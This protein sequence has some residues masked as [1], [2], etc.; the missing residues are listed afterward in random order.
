MLAAGASDSEDFVSKISTWATTFS[1]AILLTA[2]LQGQETTPAPTPIFERDVLPIL[3][4]SCLKCHGGDEPEAGLDL[5]TPGAI[6]KG[7]DNGPVVVRNAADKSI[8]FEKISS[9]EMPPGEVKLTE[10]AVQ[11]L[12]AWID[13]GARALQKVE[14]APLVSENDRQHWAFRPPVRPSVPKVRQETR[15]R[16]PVDSFLLEKLEAKNL[17]FADDADRATLLRRAYLDLWGLP[18]T[19]EAL[20]GFAADQGPDSYELLLDRLLASPRFGERWGR[21]WLDVVGYTDTIGFDQ[22]S[23]NIM[24][25]D[26]KW[27]YRDYVIGCLNEDL[28]YTRFVTEQLAG[29]ELVDWRNAPRFTPEIVRLLTA[30]GYLRTARDQTHEDVGNIPQNYFGILNDTL[31]IVGNSLLGLTLHCAQ[32]HNHKFDPLPQQDYYRLMAVFTPAYNPLDWR[33]V[34]PWAKDIQ[35]RSLADVS[36]VELAEIDQHNR[37]VDRQIAALQS[38]LAA[39]REPHEA[40][41]REPKLETLPEAIRSDTLAAVKTPA[42]NRN[43]V[44][45][46]LADKFEPLL[47]VAAEEVAAQ[48]TS[49]ERALVDGISSEI[50]ALDLTHRSH[51]KIQA[52]FDVGAP[53]P[54]YL[55]TRGNYQTPGEEVQPGFLTVLTDPN[56]LAEVPAPE[57]S[58]VTSGRRLALSR[59]L[60]EPDTP[61]SALLARVMV[62]RMWQHLF[63]QGLVPS[64]DNFGRSGEPPTH[65]ELLEWLADEF[66]RTGWR[67]K[68]MLKMLMMSTAYR[69]SSRAARANS[70]NGTADA[71]TTDPGNQLLSRMRLRRLEAEAIRDAILAVSDRLDLTMGGPPVMVRARPDGLVAVDEKSLPYPEAEGRRSIYLLCRRSYNLSLLTTFDQPLV[72]QNCPRRDVSAVPLQSLAM[73]NDGFLVEQS[74]HFSDRVQRTAGVSGA[75]AVRTAFRL[76]LSRTATPDEFAICSRLLEQQTAAYQKAGRS[77][78]EAA[79]EALVQLCQAILNTSEFIYVE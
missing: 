18:P 58:A 41:L 55:L 11:V 32:C 27:R 60:T 5:R 73:L 59:W 78:D 70:D 9:G 67:V 61:A 30:T 69:Q 4:A 79:R 48:L 20:D 10:E 49:E 24:Q 7:G 31:A 17:G 1:G 40:R 65:P 25:S 51:G 63:G 53:P 43:D 21:H 2:A 68:P 75:E 6:L 26:G 12:R 66:A 52:L 29:D 35:D 54:T 15:V 57:S 56:R 47:R 28:P 19:L 23:A 74:R 76:A 64:V 44:Q 34:Y 46:Y 13:A 38:R 71:E 36:A 8:L 37:E 22:D 16:T 33:P 42:E 77:A 14:I 50:Q 45:K 39:V 3:S 62:N 72:A